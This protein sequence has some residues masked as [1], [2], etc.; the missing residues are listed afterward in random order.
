MIRVAMGAGAE[1]AAAVAT[2]NSVLRARLARVAAARAQAAAD[3]PAA[4]PLP[5]P[6]PASLERSA[7]NAT[8]RAADRA[9]GLVL[10]PDAVEARGI[11]LAELPELLPEHALIAVIEAPGERLGV[12]ALCPATV[13]SLIEI[14]AMRHVTSRPV[15]V[16]RAT[17]ADAAIAADFVNLLLEEYSDSVARLPGQGALRGFRYASY[18]DDP[19]PLGLMLDDNG[20]RTLTIKLRIGPSGERRGSLFIAVPAVK[21]AAEP[22]GNSAAAPPSC[23]DGAAAAASPE[24]VAP[25]RAAGPGL[26][27]AMLSAPVALIGIL[28]RRPISLREV[29]ALVPGHIL[30]LPRDVLEACSIETPRGQKLAT[31]KLGEQDGRHALR[32]RGPTHQTGTAAGAARPVTPPH[33]TPDTV[34]AQADHDAAPDPA[35]LQ[36]DDGAPLDLSMEDEFRTTPVTEEAAILPMQMAFS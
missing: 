31:G 7:A 27:Q 11:T 20:F 35:L 21:E 12:V 32:L 1:M 17:R 16:R 5:A 13:A 26:S 10:V 36:P 6:P 4:A 14:Q 23:A 34:A 19:R 18:L 25:I 9:S 29:R 22:A 24:G 8:A 15:E 3:D 33:D 28:C 2:P 30:T